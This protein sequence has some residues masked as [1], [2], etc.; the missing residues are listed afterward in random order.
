MDAGGDLSSAAKGS[1]IGLEVAGSSPVQL[2][3]I[4]SLLLFTICVVL[5]PVFHYS[6]VYIWCIASCMHVHA[7]ASYLLINVLS[8][9]GGN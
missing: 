2:P 7:N 3:F 9:M 1:A 6:N 4:H 8:N 5:Q